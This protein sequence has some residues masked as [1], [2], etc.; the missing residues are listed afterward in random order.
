MPNEHDTSNYSQSSRRTFLK[1]IGGAVASAA[2]VSSANNACA[3]KSS[4]NMST[5]KSNTKFPLSTNSYPWGTFY[6]RQ[7]RDYEADLA[8]TISEIKKSGADCLEP[9]LK[10][11]AYVDTLSDELEKQ[12]VGM[13]SVYVNS[14]LHEAEKAKESIEWVMA[15]VRQAK[16]RMGTQIV[17]TNPSPIQWGGSQN[18]NDDQLSVQ[19]D[20]LENLGRAIHAEGMTLAYH[21]HD[22][23]F[24]EGARE[25][26]HMLAATDPKYVKLCL[27]AHWVFRGAG[28]SN[29]A[30]HDIIKLYGDRIAEL[31]IRQSKDGIWTEVFGDGDIDYSRLTRELVNLGVSPLV[32]M[33]QAVESDSPNTMNGLKA[34]EISHAIGREVFAPFIS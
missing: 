20:A 2:L 1:G 17:V 26:H 22:P 10:S 32:T 16:K 29:V 15:I 13:I 25:F 7:G 28:D 5:G 8:F 27:D 9:N 23:E 33:E 30:L 19:R 31:H 21:S 12:G 14:E 18:K 34:H 3:K 4:S 11:L 6:K 24:R